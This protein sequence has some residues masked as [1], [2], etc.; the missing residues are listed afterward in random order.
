MRPSLKVVTW[1]VGVFML[2]NPCGLSPIGTA[3]A[4]EESKPVKTMRGGALATAGAYQFE[5]FFY[6]TG[7]RVFPQDAKGA[8]LDAS[9]LTGSATFYHPNSPNPWFARPLRPA[10]V[11]PG[12]ALESLDLGIDLRT[13]PP[14]GARVA[15]EIA[16]LPEPGKPTARFT[17]PVQFVMVPAEPAATQVGAV[18][19][20]RHSYTPGDYSSL[21]YPIGEIGTLRMV[22]PRVFR[23]GLGPGTRPDY[24]EGYVSP[25]SLGGY[26][27]MYPATPPTVTGNGSYIVIPYGHMAGWVLVT[28]R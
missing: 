16:G 20:P 22:E 6:T 14:T 2:A 19:G 17:V 5:V 12:Q 21:T 9:K 13:V 15:F 26:G 11:G 8:A 7:L 24:S 25:R 27:A 10:A 3:T 1:A 28:P 18:A 23:R 4:Q